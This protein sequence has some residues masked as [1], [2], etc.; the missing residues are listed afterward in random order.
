MRG[1]TVGV[2]SGGWVWWRTREGAEVI[3]LVVLPRVTELILLESEV[4]SAVATEGAIV[5]IGVIVANI[6]TEGFI[7]DGDAGSEVGPV[8]AKLTECSRLLGCSGWASQLE[9]ART[10]EATIV[11]STPQTTCLLIDIWPHGRVGIF[12]VA[13]DCP[14]RTHSV[15]GALGVV[16]ECVIGIWAGLSKGRRRIR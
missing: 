9:L 1:I 13:I 6:W 15:A 2:C 11:S 8:T 16:V 5:C 14:R 4:E 7:D 12:P 3:I 10:W